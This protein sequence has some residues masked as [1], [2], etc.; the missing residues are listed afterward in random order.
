MNIS[1]CC[2]KLCT[3]N[4]GHAFNIQG[5]TAW[6]VPG[7]KTN[8][9]STY[10]MRR[11]RTLIFFRGGGGL[12]ISSRV[13][14]MFNVNLKK[15]EFAGVSI[16]IPFFFLKIR[17][18]TRSDVMFPHSPSSAWLYISFVTCH[19]TVQIKKILIEDKIWHKDCL[20][21]LFF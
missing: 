15:F 8:V 3:Y 7:N 5:R 19:C 12:E 17:A 9:L 4:F 1:R 20:V 18:G 16:L 10:I 6:K 2:L 14:G 13:W 21:I 11:S